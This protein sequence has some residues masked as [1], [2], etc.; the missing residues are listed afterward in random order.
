MYPTR[1]KNISENPIWALLQAGCRRMVPVPR[2]CP[3]CGRSHISSK[4]KHP[5]RFN[6][7]AAGDRKQKMVC[8]M[9]L[10]G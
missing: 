10:S 3:Y 4:H 9:C 2:I 5:H 7:I 8:P 6:R 1:D